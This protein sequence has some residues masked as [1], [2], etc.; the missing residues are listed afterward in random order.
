MSAEAEHAVG[1]ETVHQH[2]AELITG[3]RMRA[4]PALT[5]L[6]GVAA[7]RVLTTNYENGIERSAESRG[8]E[9]VP[10]LP[11]DVRTTCL[12][13]ATSATVGLG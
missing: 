13:L 9:P 3:S 12:L 5:A 4:T 1:T 11:S 10:L 2:L 6:C 7:G 8:L